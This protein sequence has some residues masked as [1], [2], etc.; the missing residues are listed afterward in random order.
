AHNTVAVCF[1]SL[2]QR[3]SVSRN[4]IEKF[5][6][7]VPQTPETLMVFDINLRQHFYSKEIIENS[8]KRSN[9]LKI[10]DEELVIVAKMFEVPSD[11][12]YQQCRWFIQKYGLKLVILTCGAK[13][14]IVVTPDKEFHAAT[15]KVDV[16]DTVGAGDSFT[17]A[18]TAALLK[19]KSI[20]EGHALASSLATYVCTQHG[21]MPELP[22]T[23]KKSLQ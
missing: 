15:P 6:D 3:N 10:N 12:V 2:A 4:T 20:E 1:G 16:A 23:F 22:D 19:G 9:I 13:G 7:A 17:A 14:S 5:L 8:L 18:F 21:A 11:D